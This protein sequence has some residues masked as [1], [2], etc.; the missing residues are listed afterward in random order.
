MGGMARRLPALLGSCLLLSTGIVRADLSAEMRA[1]IIADFPPWHPNP[2][3]ASTQATRTEEAPA[4]LSNDPLV[5]LPDYHVKDSPLLRAGDKLRSE[6]EVQAKAMAAYKDSM[7]DLEW[8]MNS[9]YIPIISAPASARAR[10]YYEDKKADDEARRLQRL[11]LIN[12]P[13]G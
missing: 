6:R 10:A 12:A 4:P 7:T 1:K 9:W 2:A 8:A 3:E 13:G 5:L 11:Q